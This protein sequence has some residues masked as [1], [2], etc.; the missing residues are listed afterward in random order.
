MSGRIFM[1][2]VGNEKPVQSYTPVVPGFVIFPK[3][4]GTSFVGEL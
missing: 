2:P 1:L 3:K 4:R